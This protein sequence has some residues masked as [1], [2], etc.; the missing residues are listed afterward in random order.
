M[1]LI[2]L[3]LGNPYALIGIAA[4]FAL[5]IGSAIWFKHE[6]SVAKKGEAAAIEMARLK[7]EDADRW[8]AAAEARLQQITGL[9]DQMTRQNAAVVAAAAA[10]DR[11]EQRAAGAATQAAQAHA[12]LN[13]LTMKWKER[14]N[15]R[16]DDVRPLGPV[17]CSA[18]A[19]LYGAAK[20]C[21]NPSS[22]ASN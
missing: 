21:T 9:S 16:P 5:S 15:A 7:T 3:L 6:A 8:Q 4:A 13:D 18:Y 14:A 20:A 2:K 10:R 1:G 12:A 11:A 17:A 22:A 19:S